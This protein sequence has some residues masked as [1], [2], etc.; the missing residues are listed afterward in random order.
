MLWSE[1][2]TGK[3]KADFFDPLV[4]HLEEAAVDAALCPKKVIVQLIGVMGKTTHKKFSCVQSTNQLELL[5]RTSGEKV[6]MSQ[7]DGML[8]A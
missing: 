7:T 2:P 5:H 3:L 6:S 4:T 8:N 1:K